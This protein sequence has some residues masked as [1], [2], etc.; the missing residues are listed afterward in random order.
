MGIDQTKI[1]NYDK[2]HRE[3]KR[4]TGFFSKL[5]GINEET[6]TKKPFRLIDDILE[7]KKTEEG[8]IVQ[9]RDKEITYLVRDSEVRDRMFRKLNFLVSHIN[10]ESQRFGTPK[11]K[12]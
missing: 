11:G 8:L 9:F 6:G 5:F 7:M 12:N 4:E 10:R 2:N 3:E 1:Y